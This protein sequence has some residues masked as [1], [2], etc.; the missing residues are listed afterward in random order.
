VVGLE[1]VV[2]KIHPW[3]VYWGEGP[4]WYGESIFYW[5]L[6]LFSTRYT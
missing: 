2:H 3:T 5:Y 4:M 1:F 6:V